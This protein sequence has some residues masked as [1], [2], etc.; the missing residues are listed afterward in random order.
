MPLSRNERWERS[1]RVM[2]P[3]LRLHYLMLPFLL[4]TQDGQLLENEW[5][6]RGICL[7]LLF[8]SFMFLVG[9]SEFKALQAV[10]DRVVLSNLQYGFYCT[11]LG[12][13]CLMM[14]FQKLMF[15]GFFL[16]L[17]NAIFLMICYSQFSRSSTFP[18]SA[19]LGVEVLRK[20]TFLLL[21]VWVVKWFSFVGVWVAVV[22]SVVVF[23]MMN[24][25]WTKI[26]RYRE[27]SMH[28]ER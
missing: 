8:T 5:V 1:T 15:T 12:C 16:L 3:M 21:P 25:G 6:F 20:A 4:L 24:K 26:A 19:L 27:S 17:L 2:L 10:Q 13:V 23:I 28:S 9:L 14:P 18:D 7:V 22:L 11:L